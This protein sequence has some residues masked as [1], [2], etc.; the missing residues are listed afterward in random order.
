[1]TSEASV[2]E[3]SPQ[4]TSPQET[5]L[6]DLYRTGDAVRPQL[7]DAKQAAD[8]HGPLL[9][10]VKRTCGN[11]RGSLL[12]VGCGDG[13]VSW[14]LSEAGFDV[15]GIDLHAEGHVPTPHERLVFRQGSALDLPFPDAS[16]DVVVTNQTVEHLP[17]PERGLREM[18]RVL[19]PRGQLIVVG[20]NLLSPLA[21]V[22]AATRWV[23]QN[24]PRST[25]F[26][27]KPGMPRH[28]LGNTL[29]EVLGL[30]VRNWALIGRKLIEPHPSFTMREPDVVP[31]FH[32]DNDATYLCNPID[33]KR[34]LPDFGCKVTQVGAYDRPPGSWILVGGTWIAGEKL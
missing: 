34:R 10:F 4:E 20:P 31:P 1:M 13:W 22:Y 16:F 23:W 9:D 5:S 2:Q 28:P 3:T 24:R 25:I 18:V 8:R 19:R 30:M 33:L 12:E 15:T 11:A 26:V 27:R 14:L 21:S 29:P 7:A 17:D 32:G 6:Q